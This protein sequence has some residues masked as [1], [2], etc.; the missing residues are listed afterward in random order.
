MYLCGLFLV[1]MLP[2]EASHE[3]IEIIKELAAVSGFVTSTVCLSAHIMCYLAVLFVCHI[4]CFSC[5]GLFV[6][7]DISVCLF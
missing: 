6:S 3:Y 7:C 2:P 4:S 5:C 1:Q